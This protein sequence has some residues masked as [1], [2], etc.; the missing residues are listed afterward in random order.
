MAGMLYVAI[1]II[2]CETRMACRTNFRAA[3]FFDW[4][5]SRRLVQKVGLPQEGMNRLHCLSYG[6]DAAP[7]EVID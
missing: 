3:F 2:G 6:R 7:I 1:G 5:F 4:H